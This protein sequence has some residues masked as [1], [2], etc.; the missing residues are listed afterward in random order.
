MTSLSVYPNQ[1]DSFETKQDYTSRIMASHVNKIQDASINIEHELGIGLKGNFNNLNERISRQI[2]PNGNIINRYTNA[3]SRSLLPGEVVIL[4]PAST[5]NVIA[6]GD[7]NNDNV[8]GVVSMLSLAGEECNTVVRGIAAVKII[9]ETGDITIGDFL[10]TSS[11]EG[12]AT[13]AS[14]TVK[15]VLGASAVALTAGSSGV[16]NMIVEVSGY[17]LPQHNHLNNSEGGLLGYGAVNSTNLL[18]NDIY[19][20]SDLTVSKLGVTTLTVSGFSNFNNDVFVNDDLFVNG[21]ATLGNDPSTDTAIVCGSLIISSTPSLSGN[22][23]GTIILGTNNYVNNTIQYTANDNLTSFSNPISAPVANLTLVITT[24]ITADDIFLGDTFSG[25]I[26]DNNVFIQANGLNK[27]LYNAITDDDIGSGGEYARES[28]VVSYLAANQIT[29]VGDGTTRYYANKRIE[30]IDS[31]NVSTFATVTNAIFS[32]P[33]TIITVTPA[34]VPATLSKIKY[35]AAAQEN[36]GVTDASNPAND[37]LLDHVTDTTIHNSAGSRLI[38]E[39]LTSQVTGGVNIFYATNIFK[40]ASMSVYLDGLRKLLTT[41]YTVDGSLKK[42]TTVGTPVSGTSLLVE[43]ELSG[44]ASTFIFGDDLSSQITG[45]EVN[46]TPTYAFK[47]GTVQLYLNEL[48]KTPITDFTENGYQQIVMTTAPATGQTLIVDYDT[49]YAGD[50]VTLGS[51][52]FRISN[53][54]TDGMTGIAS[55]MVPKLQK[56]TKMQIGASN[57]PVGSDLVV[58]VKKNGVS[59]LNPINMLKLLDGATFGSITSFLSTTLNEG[60]KIT[61]DIVSTGSTY[62]GGDNLYINILTQS[63]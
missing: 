13:K 52:S 34:S 63:Y 48:R 47:P 50:S 31:S 46:F 56:I 53:T 58:D 21:T 2:D 22:A 59:I 55:Y 10:T 41:D 19:I 8:A 30:M 15:R 43:Y 61:I 35:Y 12:F 6:T 18:Q 14:P 49:N 32:T 24:S 36:I 1:Y 37:T 23:D 44:Q 20:M 33:N 26:N 51:V 16:F 45:S 54:L 9:A 38:I 17:Q 39:D 7:L 4:H 62:P 25:Q 42:I 40:D 29:L 11:Y 28:A 3:M 5:L 57:A 27:N 60:D